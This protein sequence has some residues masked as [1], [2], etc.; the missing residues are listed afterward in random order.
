MNNYQ[1]IPEDLNIFEYVK[2]D[3]DILEA[4][5]KYG[6]EI[7][8]NKKALC[9]FH[10]DTKPS[11]SFKH[12]RFFCF[13]CGEKGSLLDL[14]M[15]LYN[16]EPLGAV[17]KISNDFGLRID[18]KTPYIPDMSHIRAIDEKKAIIKGFEKWIDETYSSY[19][20]LA[21]FYLENMEKYKPG[22]DEKFHP[23]YVTAVQRLPQVN[24]MLDIL[25]EGKD[26]DKIQMYKDL[27]KRK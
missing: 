17:E 15:K 4:A 23:Q 7:N 12:N 6:I 10:N 27:A 11:M 18:F 8:R 25:F 22:D 14:V 1:S 13:S 24:Y 16:L 26:E 3:V 9:I 5:E 21:K 20:L 2:D 19:A